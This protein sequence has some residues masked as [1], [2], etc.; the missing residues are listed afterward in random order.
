MN[1]DNKLVVGF[2]EK[3]RLFNEFFTSKSAPITND[4][5]LSRLVVLNSENNL[6]AISFNNDDIL[7]ITRSL[8]IN[9]AHVHGSISTRIIKICEKAIFQPLSI[10]YKNCIGDGIF[11]DLWKK[12]NIVPIHKKGDKQLL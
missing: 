4:S 12:S 1:V 5:S 9:K 3:A 7:N 8:N 6:S 10:T 2:K 11:P